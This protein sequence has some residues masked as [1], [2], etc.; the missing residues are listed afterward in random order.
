[1][2]EHWKSIQEV[3]SPGAVH[4]IAYSKDE[5]RIFIDCN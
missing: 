4:Y 2:V 1:M 5:L 3:P